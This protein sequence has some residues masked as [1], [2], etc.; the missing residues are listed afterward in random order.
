MVLINIIGGA[1]TGFFVALLD[2]VPTMTNTRQFK[3]NFHMVKKMLKGSQTPDLPSGYPC[4]SFSIFNDI[5]E[6]LL[7]S[8]RQA[9]RDCPGQGV[10]PLPARPRSLC[11]T[12]SPHQ[13]PPTLHGRRTTDSHQIGLQRRT[14][15]SLRATGGG[16]LKVFLQ[17]PVAC[18]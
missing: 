18:G 9:Q 4:E 10:L 14:A 11:E 3:I 1:E 7:W 16:A 12:V 8:R 13:G 5:K 6:L 2:L 15:V 17:V